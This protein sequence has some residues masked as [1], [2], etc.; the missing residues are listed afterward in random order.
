M[1]RSDISEVKRALKPKFGNIKEIWAT[2]ANMEKTILFSSKKEMLSLSEEEQLVYSNL[3]SKVL[4]GKKDKNLFVF[5]T[6]TS[7]EVE[8]TLYA[9]SKDSKDEAV[10]RL[11]NKIISEYKAD[12]S[13]AVLVATVTYDIP[14]YASDGTKLEDSDGLYHFMVGAVCPTKLEKPNLIYKRDKKFFEKANRDFV[15]QAPEIGLLYPVF[16]SREP[17]ANKLLY[18]AKKS[19]KDSDLHPELLSNIFEADIPV[20]SEVQM[21]DFAEKVSESFEGKKDV[22]KLLDVKNSIEEKQFKLELAG[23]EPILSKSDINDIFT[24]HGGK[25]VEFE[26]DVSLAAVATD[27]LVI[28]GA[29]GLK[30]SLTAEDVKTIIQKDIDG[31][32]YLLIPTE[33]LNFN[34]VSLR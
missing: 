32:N 30:I 33:D 3:F 29:N 23:E 5:P 18:Y 17:N 25:E 14:S 31:R 1:L 13:F 22:R 8:D 7:K 28:S 26:G 19:K 9:I 27:K 15:L 10:K 2:Y 34:G 6:D 11:T 16:E 24:K 12:D 4:S 20:I 21:I